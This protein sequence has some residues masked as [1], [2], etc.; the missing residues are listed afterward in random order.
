MPSALWV[1]PS[2]D[3]EWGDACIA[4]LKVRQLLRVDNSST[5][6]GVARSWNI[7]IVAARQLAVD[8]LVVCSESLRFAR[9]GGQDFENG[10]AGQLCRSQ[11]QGFHLVG[12]RLDMF[13]LVGRFDETF[14]PAYFEDADWLRRARLLGLL[15]RAEDSPRVD[16]DV[17]ELDVAHSLR[18]G[19][20]GKD[21]YGASAARYFAKWGGYA[22][23]ETFAEP[24]EGRPCG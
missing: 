4:T 14:S 24:Y 9:P 15:D 2:I 12:I 17:D 13:D 19:R 1:L 6:R 8:Y 10:L 20:I 11:C 18:S 5:N 22:P 23:D 16:V 3:A 7:G 21:V